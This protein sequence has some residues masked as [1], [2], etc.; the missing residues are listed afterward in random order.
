M[1]FGSDMH[2]V[3]PRFGGSV[4]IVEAAG[5]L[6]AGV[7]GGAVNCVYF[8][9]VCPRAGEGSGPCPPGRLGSQRS[10]PPET[11]RSTPG[12]RPASLV[13]KTARPRS[14]CAGQRQAGQ[15]LGSRPVREAAGRRVCPGACGLLFRASV[16]AAR[17][18]SARWWPHT[19]S[20][21]GEHAGLR[22][23]GAGTGTGRPAEV[24]LRQ[25]APHLP[26]PDLHHL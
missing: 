5:Q 14:A 3:P 19:S 2:R 11:P 24:A 9:C 8:L 6:G 10:P 23:A 26:G 7:R 13:F 22:G 12:V 18:G 25:G 17:L 1:G 20:H 16:S 21:S 15:G 4:L